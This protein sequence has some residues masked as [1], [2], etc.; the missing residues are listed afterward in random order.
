MSVPRPLILFSTCDPAASNIVAR[1]QELLDNKGL[2][3][4][5][6]LIGEGPLKEIRHYKDFSIALSDTEHLY[7][8]QV[9]ELYTKLTG[10]KPPFIIIPS[11]HRSDMNIRSLTIHPTGNFRK[12]EFGGTEGEFSGT[13]PHYQSL[14]LQT[15][16]ELW[17]GFPGS[18]NGFFTGLESLSKGDLKQ[19]GVSFEATHHGPLVETPCFFIEIGSTEDEWGL[20]KPAM[21]LSATL[22]KLIQV[23]KRR[24]RDGEQGYGEGNAQG[25]TKVGIGVGGGHYTPRFSKFVIQEGYRLGHIVPG[26]ACDDL[27][28]EMARKLLEKTPGTNTIFVHGK[29]NR[30]YARLFLDIEPGLEVLVLK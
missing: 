8:E 22:W 23:R 10:H 3:P 4:L 9:D 14:A 18:M 11:K 27:T 17:K 21:L 26:Y 20:R 12:A 13:D 16:N 30:K 15:L 2:T 25:E 29:K 6:I 24:Q 28:L 7:L 19:F 5:E 1:F